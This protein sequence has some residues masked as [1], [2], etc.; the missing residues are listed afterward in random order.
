MPLRRGTWR[1][2][3]RSRG[4]NAWIGARTPAARG[5]SPLTRGKQRLSWQRAR[6]RGLIP[7]HAGKT[8][9]S[10]GCRFRRGAHPRSRGENPSSTRLASPSRGSSPLTRGKPGAS[11]TVSVSSG[12]IPAH[13]GKTTGVGLAPDRERAHPRS[14]GEN[15]G[16]G[17]YCQPSRGSSPLTR[18]KRGE[19]L[20]RGGGRGLIPAHAGKT[21]SVSP[22]LRS[23][24]AHPRSRW[25][26]RCAA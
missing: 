5:S 7:A 10:G 4:E 26:N 9:K 16:C 12:L 14:R 18:G 6:R 20:P 13:A 3:P 22:Q 17:Q 2:H 15:L 23:W 8:C 19:L 1:A 25:E 24:W 21:C 11:P